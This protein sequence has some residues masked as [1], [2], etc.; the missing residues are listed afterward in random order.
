MNPP[1]YT[2]RISLPEDNDNVILRHHL[3]LQARVE[4]GSAYFMYVKMGFHSIAFEKGPFRCFSYREQCPVLLSR[5]A[6][7]TTSGYITDDNFLRLLV[8]RTWLYNV[9]PPDPKKT[10]LTVLLICRIPVVCPVGSYSSPQ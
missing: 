6:K 4:F 2:V 10:W 5:I 7:T 9:Y 8:L 3:Y 1:S